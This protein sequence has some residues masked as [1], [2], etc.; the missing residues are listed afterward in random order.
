M[1]RVMVVEDEAIAARAVAVMLERIGCEVTAIV[2]TGEGA[3]EGASRHCPDLVLM[4]IR[5]KGSMDGI[6][7]ASII[8]ERFGLCVVFVSAYLPDELEAQKTSGTGYD[9][10]S[11]PIDQGDLAMVVQRVARSL[12]QDHER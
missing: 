2:D 12:G 8:R 9:F 4:D 11:K 7:A 6:E 1:L 3:I 10:L 5:L